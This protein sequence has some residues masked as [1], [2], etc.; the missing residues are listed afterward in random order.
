MKNLIEKQGFLNRHLSDLPKQ[1]VKVKILIGNTIRFCE[2]FPFNESDCHQIEKPHD[3]Y[4]GT[5]KCMETGIGFNAW[6]QN[7]SE[8]IYYYVV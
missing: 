4:L 2:W 5:A 6:A 3:G 8:F 7:N 1:K